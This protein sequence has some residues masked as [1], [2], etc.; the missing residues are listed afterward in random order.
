MWRVRRRRVPLKT[1]QLETLTQARPLRFTV[2]P[3]SRRSESFCPTF[4]RV[5]PWREVG[6]PADTF[7]DRPS[8][9]R[10]AFCPQIIPLQRARSTRSQPVVRGR[11]SVFVTKINVSS[12]IKIDDDLFLSSRGRPH[13]HCL[14]AAVRLAAPRGAVHL[15]NLGLRLRPSAA[16]TALSRLV[17][18]R[19][20]QL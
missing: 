12:G 13:L 16:V 10:R 4:N 18:W 1:S 17:W 20:F 15:W 2:T 14:H 8:A 6:P 19:Y 11:K 3:R 7:W 9:V 5:G